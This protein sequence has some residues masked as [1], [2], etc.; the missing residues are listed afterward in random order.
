MGIFPLFIAVVD[1]Q[2]IS[3]KSFKVIMDFASELNNCLAIS[4][5]K[6]NH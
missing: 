6:Y 2:T 1:L 4:S 3:Y 5:K